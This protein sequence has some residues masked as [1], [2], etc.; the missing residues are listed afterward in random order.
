M[1]KIP[2]LTAILQ[3]T[4]EAL[5]A[6]DISDTWCAAGGGVPAFQR[7]IFR[8]VWLGL[9]GI[10]SK[11]DEDGFKPLALEAFAFPA[12]DAESLKVTNGP[13]HR[14]RARAEGL[15]DNTPQ[16][17]TCWPPRAP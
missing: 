15:A 8:G 14:S 12:E 5:T 13:S 6:L 7:R 10:T 4:V 9:A 2:A 3:A 1:G 11:E 16:T 17:D